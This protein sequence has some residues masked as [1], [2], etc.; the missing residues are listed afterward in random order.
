MLSSPLLIP[1][2]LAKYMYGY[3]MPLSTQSAR[4]P[5]ASDWTAQVCEFPPPAPPR[6]R[7]AR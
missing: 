2:N 7:A 5:L 1:N 4:S 3:G 6:L